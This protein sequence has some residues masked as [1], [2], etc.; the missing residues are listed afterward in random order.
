MSLTVETRSSTIYIWGTHLSTSARCHLSHHRALLKP[1]SASGETQKPITTEARQD[2]GPGKPFLLDLQALTLGIKIVEVRTTQSQSRTTLWR[3]M[4]RLRL[5][6]ALSPIVGRGA[7]VM[8]DGAAASRCAL[9]ATCTAL[10][11]AGVHSGRESAPSGCPVMHKKAQ[12]S[13]FTLILTHQMFSH[14]YP[15]AVLK[16]PPPNHHCPAVQCTKTRKP[17]ARRKSLIQAT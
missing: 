8:C 4:H 9:S 13:H 2:A 14:M 3:N 15:G 12:R 16:V 5:V 6:A 17:A 1:Y 11:G 10:T 7:W